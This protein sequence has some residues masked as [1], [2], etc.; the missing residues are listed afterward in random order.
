MTPII[1]GDPKYVNAYLR[2]SKPPTD[3]EYKILKVD[4][5]IYGSRQKDIIDDCCYSSNSV[6][7]LVKSALGKY[8][9]NEEKDIYVNCK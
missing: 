6:R 1:Y 2:Q 9:Q 8:L 7:S 5:S 4:L 3:R